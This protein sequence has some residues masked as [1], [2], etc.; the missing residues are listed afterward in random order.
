VPAADPLPAAPGFTGAV[1]PASVWL[2]RRARP[3]AR[4]GKRQERALLMFPWVGCSTEIRCAQP[5]SS[6]IRRDQTAHNSW[7]GRQSGSE[8]AGVRRALVTAALPPVIACHQAA[9]GSRDELHSSWGFRASD[10]EPHARGHRQPAVSPARNPQPPRHAATT[11][12]PPA[13]SARVGVIAA[14]SS[15]KDA[16][17]NVPVHPRPPKPDQSSRYPQRPAPPSQTPV[18]VA[19]RVRK[20]ALRPFREPPASGA[21][22]REPVSLLD[23]PNPAPAP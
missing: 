4:A 10:G 12:R 6:P 11:S 19:L 8:H 21:P 9:R 15:P 17:T 13:A 23:S 16:S 14:F 2:G 18:S 3:R 5:F 1:A 7:Q 20:P 22:R